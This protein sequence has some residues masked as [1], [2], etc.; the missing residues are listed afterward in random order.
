MESCNLVWFDHDYRI[1]DHPA[2]RAATEAGMGVIAITVIHPTELSMHAHGFERM[3]SRRQQALYQVLQELRTNLATLH[4]PFF[5]MIDTYE[6]ALTRVQTVV[7][8]NKIYASEPRAYLEDK[9]IRQLQEKVAIPW[10]IH[11]GRALLVREP[12]LASIPDVFTSFRKELQQ[13]ATYRPSVPDANATPHLDIAMADDLQK[14]NHHITLSF[15]LGEQAAKQRLHYYLYESNLVNRYKETRNGMLRLDDSSKLSFHLALG[16]LSATQVHE[17]L[18]HYEKTVHKNDST[19]WLRFEL[20]WREFFH[21]Q[22]QLNL[23]IYIKPQAHSPNRTFIQAWIEGETGFPLVDAA[24]KELAETGYMSNR[25]RQNVASF[26]V[27]Y[28]KQDWRVGADYF[29]SQLIDYDPSSNYLNWQYVAGVGHDPRD[30]RIFNVY[31]QG[32]QYDPD[33]S[34]VTT[35]LPELQ[36]RS[37]AQIYQY[38]AS[39]QDQ[40]RPKPLVKMPFK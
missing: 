4:I 40:E 30:Q 12:W 36:G 32:L 29:A 19:Y 24:M 2:L 35:W 1:T 7:N 18:R 10:S 16:T 27:H 31:K 23:N 8:I 21:W 11:P 37:A 13:K 15:E 3:S 28:L 39:L 6:N 26:F 38:H 14:L 22:A 17:T 5:V 34:Y 33:A 9:W 20:W 25:A